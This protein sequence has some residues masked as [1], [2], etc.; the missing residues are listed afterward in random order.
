MHVGSSGT[1]SATAGDAVSVPTASATEVATAQPS[2]SVIPVAVPTGDV[3]A[4]LPAAPPVFKEPERVGTGFYWAAVDIFH[5]ATEGGE[6]S[7]SALKIIR[8]VAIVIVILGLGVCVAAVEVA[9]WIHLS[10]GGGMIAA[11]GGAASGG[12]AIYAGGAKLV[13]RRQ[14]RRTQ[15][16]APATATPP[17]PSLVVDDGGQAP[18]TG[19]HVITVLPTA[20]QPAVEIPPPRA[21]SDQPAEATASDPT[22]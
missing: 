9:H 3:S 13:Q 17:Q 21:A 2:P 6:Q 1:G 20:P 10:G 16:T 12:G 11:I 14:A 4:R 22:A 18:G 8:T 19:A 5:R 15:T 7:K